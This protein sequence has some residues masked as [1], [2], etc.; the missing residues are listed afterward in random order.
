MINIFS[1][2]VA[3]ATFAWLTSPSQG[4]QEPRSI[5]IHNNS[6]SRI[7]IHWINPQTK[8]TV[9]QSNPHVYNGAT[10]SLNSFAT[11]KFEVREL[12]GKSGKCNGDDQTCRVGYFTVNFN[13]EQGK[14]KL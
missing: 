5:N 4:A 11:H 2:I 3:L 7:E 9:L 13:D 14:Y 12:P 8:E 10:F 6:G 1:T